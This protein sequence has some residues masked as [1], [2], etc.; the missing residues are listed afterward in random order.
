MARVRCG[1]PGTVF[2]GGADYQIG[3]ASRLPERDDWKLDLWLAV[4]RGSYLLVPPDM[5]TRSSGLVASTDA[6]GSL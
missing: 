6:I 2:V 1:A 3:D 4:L 5:H